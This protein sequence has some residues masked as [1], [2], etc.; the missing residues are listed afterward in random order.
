MLRSRG[1]GAEGIRT[2][3][4]CSAIA[5]PTLNYLFQ[6]NRL[7]LL[8]S[9]LF[10]RCHTLSQRAY[11]KKATIRKRGNKWQ[12]QIRRNGHKHY[13]RSF[14]TKRDAEKWSRQLETGLELGIVVEPQTKQQVIVG[15]SDP[16]TPTLGDLVSRYLEQVTP[17]KR[18]AVPETY[19]LNT[20]L[21]CYQML[22][23]TPCDELRTQH[24]AE[25]R[26]TRLSEGKA[27][28]TVKREIA[29]L[30]HVL[31]IA[32]KEWGARIERNP[33]TDLSLPRFN[34]ARERRLNPGEYERLIE[35]ARN[36]GT[37]HLA[38]IIIFAVETAM[39]R[40]EMLSLQWG[41]VDLV[42]RVATLKGTAT[43]N[44]HRR[45][46][47]LSP[48]AHGLVQ[49]LREAHSG[50]KN[51]LLSHTADQRT[52]LSGQHSASQNI[53]PVSANAVRLAWERLTNRLGVKD[54]RF[55]DLRHEAV[56]RLFEKGLTVPEVAS[57][58][59]HRDLRMLGRYAHP[60]LDSI[61]SRLN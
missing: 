22:A 14:N 3:D 49:R 53:F 29:T 41:D 21:S 61:L 24:F 15:N 18:G 39:R 52:A 6:N 32:R 9:S 56:S 50:N 44:G 16:D 54:L 1:G 23:E 43:K 37:P 47:P 13:S 55:H 7:A 17:N 27:S 25:F 45:V 8:M 11:G 42:K 46:I 33:I 30:G 58:S 4:L 2:P 57:I 48:T 28:S 5:A 36:T 20:F 35:G 60:E 34:D 40:R 12:A 51:L 26:D 19:R 10:L 38:E 59:G 31:E